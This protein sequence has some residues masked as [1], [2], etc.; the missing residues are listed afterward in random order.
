MEINLAF[1]Q[2]SP[3]FKKPQ[4]NLASIGKSLSTLRDTIVVLPELCHCGYQFKN[5]D[6]LLPFAETV[7]KGQTISSLTHLARQGNLLIIAGIAERDE[8]KIY[9]SAVAVS[10]QGVIACYRKVHLFNNEKDL[11]SSGDNFQVVDW[12]GVSVGIMICFDWFYPESVRTLARKGAEIICHPANLVLP[13]CQDAMRTRAIENRVFAV[14]ANRTGLEDRTAQGL[15]RLQFTGCSQVV[16]PRGEVLFRTGSQ[17]QL[18]GQCLVD[19]EQARDKN[20]TANNN[21]FSDLRPDAYGR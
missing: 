8:K 16:G 9:N 18:E 4:K 20:I 1:Y 3:L 12:Q 10:S 5:Q 19:L 2:F 14:T 15:E 17:E 6:E 7:D 21:I 13:F 11:F